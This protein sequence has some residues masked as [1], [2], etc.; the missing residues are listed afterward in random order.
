MMLDDVIGS[1]RDEFPLEQIQDLLARFSLEE[2]WDDPVAPY[3]RNSSQIFFEDPLPEPLAPQRIGAILTALSVQL[4]AQQ[5]R[6]MPYFVGDG[7][8]ALDVYFVA[9]MNLM[10]PLPPE[11]CP[12]PDAF[13]PGFTARE[14]EIVNALDATLLA[15]R[16]RIFAAHFRSPMEF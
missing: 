15:H 10:A 1:D 11:Q 3:T 2:D 8:S 14:P 5:A 13:R 7:L 6:G 16:D 12:M 9:F 4:K